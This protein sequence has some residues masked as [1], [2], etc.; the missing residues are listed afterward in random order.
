MKYLL[1][2]INNTRGYLILANI[3]LV[4]FLI[5]LSNLKVLP[6]GNIGD[7]LFLSFL[8]LALALYRPGW[9]FL[10]FIGTIALEN[11]NLAPVSL[12]IAVRPYQFF[13]AIT[14]FAVLVRF[15]AKRLNFKLPKF[16]F[17]DGAMIFFALAGFLSALF[18]AN[19]G[20]SLKQSVV[21][22]SF[23]AIYFLVRIFIHNMEDLKKITPFFLS[24]SVIIALYGI[25]QNVRFLHNLSSFEAMPGRPNGTFSEADWLGIFVI[26]LIAILYSI[27]YYL[28][29]RATSSN[30]A[31]IFNFQFSIFNQFS[32]SKFTILKV[33]LYIL[34]TTSYI[35]LILTV[36]RSAWLGALIV[37]VSYLLII[38]T[39][40]KLSPR[41][42]QWKNTLQIKLGILSCLVIS[43][44]IVYFFNLTSFQ[45][46]NRAESTGTG[47]QKIT[48]SCRLEPSSKNFQ[49]LGSRIDSI[50]ELNQFGCRHINLEDID[51][52]KARGNFVTEVYRTDPNVS[53]RSGIYQ[54]SWQ[55]IKAHPIL[56][57][58]WGGIG[59][60][61]GRD[62][63]GNTLNSSNIFLEI[64]LGAGIL[65]LASFVL[66]WSYIIVMSFW[67]FSKKQEKIATYS[68]FMILAWFA[69]F[70]PNLFNAGIFL[71]LLWIFGGIA[72]SL[73][74]YQ[75]E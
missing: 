9:A 20:M 16:L 56:G 24:S 17:I 57:I 41:E 26:F 27:I 33:F 29:K 71:G 36:S 52:E 35:L 66:A 63:R 75:E 18:S 62:G 70:I 65:G 55:Q 28:S 73:L 49:E 48:I 21:A 6:M 7:F 5:L 25:W 74:N 61:L 34:L 40:L 12:G 15:A 32:I 64:W 13:A 44:A 39:N 47:L 53:I 69:L 45:L 31:Q 10:F 46:F 72:V 67:A 4:F 60:V 54:K 37:T 8:F 3:L 19:R 59:E 68:L 51:A 14:I 1:E 22:F 58:G 42:W 11:I 43:V 38:F 30:D 50:D 23:V 2:K